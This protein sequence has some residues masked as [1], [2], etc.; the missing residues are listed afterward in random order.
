MSIVLIGYKEQDVQQAQ[1]I[2]TVLL[3]KYNF[4]QPGLT[5]V[6]Q[7][8]PGF[9]LGKFFSKAKKEIRVDAGKGFI[10][11][12]EPVIYALDLA[13]QLGADKLTV[14]YMPSKPPIEVSAE[15]IKT[16]TSNPDSLIFVANE[17]CTR[18]TNSTQLLKSANRFASADNLNK[19]RRIVKSIGQ[20]YTL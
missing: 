14:T 17:I 15:D 3:Q 19:N 11:A 20:K 4:T 5:V 10:G 8:K 6:G 2:N 12:S 1:E 9:S 18:H 7:E 16:V 13:S